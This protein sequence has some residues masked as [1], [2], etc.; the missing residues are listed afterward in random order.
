MWMCPIEL[1]QCV[2]LSE[3]CHKG[4]TLHAPVRHTVT[5]SHCDDSC[6]APFSDDSTSKSPVCIT[7]SDCDDKCDATFID[8]SKVHRGLSHEFGVVRLYRTT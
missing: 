1:C 8:D 6:A 2:I 7:H 3:E 4:L 5:H